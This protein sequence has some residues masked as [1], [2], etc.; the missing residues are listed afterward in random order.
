MLGNVLHD[1]AI[2][3]TEQ[4]VVRDRASE[5]GRIRE[6]AFVAGFA[7]LLL[8]LAIF[9]MATGST[10]NSHAGVAVTAAFPGAHQ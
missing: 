5:E 4:A 2:D 10:A 6:L 8:V 1:P 3:Q 7:I 9:L